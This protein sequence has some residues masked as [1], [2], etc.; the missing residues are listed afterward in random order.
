MELPVD[1]FLVGIG[2]LLLVRGEAAYQPLVIGDG[3]PTLIRREHLGLLARVER[4]I[5]AIAEEQLE[6]WGRAA[7]AG[8]AY[9]VEH[10]SEQFFDLQFDEFMA[11]PIGSVKKIYARFDQ[12][13][14]PEGEACLEAWQEG[15]PQG[16]HGQHRYEHKDFGV[17]ETEIL[18][19]FAA[20]MERHDMQP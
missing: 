11:D 6:S 4:D 12:T 16:K 17:S 8:V 1:P 10:G 3:D 18:D 14:S 13:L 20:Y 19:R 9:R 7:D 5:A 2:R 15:H